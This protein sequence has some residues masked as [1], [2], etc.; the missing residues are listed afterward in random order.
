MPGILGGALLAFTLSL[1]DYLITVFTKGVQSQTMPLYI[2][3]LV[4]R[5]VTPEINALSTVLL[6]GS[7]GLVGLSLA[8]QSGV[9]VYTRAI[10]LGGRLGLFLAGASH[11]AAVALQTE[12]PSQMLFYT[13]LTLLPLLGARKS[14]AAWWL[15]WQTAKPAG[16]ALALVTIAVVAF[17]AL[18]SVRIFVVG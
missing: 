17:A 8:A 18:L 5:G 15:E 6:V 9:E 11:L 3:S 1:D 12:P 4:R 10:G 13:L 14:F 16:R 7:M 2:Y